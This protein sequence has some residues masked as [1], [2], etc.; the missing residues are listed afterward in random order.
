MET[1]RTAKG[2][3]AAL[4]LGVAAVVIPT[5]AP[6]GAGGGLP[7][8]HA[9]GGGQLA[10]GGLLAMGYGLLTA[11][12]PCVYPL[13]PITVS[14]FG[15]KR[16]ESHGKALLLTSAYVLGMAAVFTLLGVVAA[17]SGQ[18]FGTHLGSAWVAVP[19]ALALT[20]LAAS[21]FGAFE[22]N[23]PPALTQKLS[24]VGGAGLWGA[25]LMGSVSG[26]LAAPCTGPALLGLLTFVAHSQRTGLG[27]GLLFLYAL[28]MG[29][30]FFLIGAFAVR[31]PKGGVWM[32]WVKSILGVVLLAMAVL[33]VE[34]AVP[35]FRELAGRVGHGVG[36]LGGAYLAG[37]GVAA[38]VLAGAVHLSFKS[39]AREAAWKALGVVLVVGALVMRMGA[40]AERGPGTL[41]VKAGF[42]SASAGEVSWALRFGE[43]AK[44][45][46]AFDDAVARARASG[47]PV[48]IDFFAEWC[49]ACKELDR[50]TYVSPAVVRESGRF[51]TIKVDGTNETDVVGALEDKF[52]VKG[53]PTVAFISS[54][55]EVLQAPRVTGFLPAG[56][57]LSELKKVQ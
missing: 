7:L 50:E 39:H 9:L 36:H 51:L 57:F 30:P 16:A 46:A 6:T 4:G 17:K 48:M 21:M 27:A 56:D 31:L 19:V 33:Y 25:V 24:T 42:L 32:E 54:K 47:R 49:A 5:L 43:S 23:L 28:G 53:L 11:L 13:I 52:E 35:A 29:L 41:W 26:F 37:L 14:V 8:E 2:L 34:D 20:L 22:L 18:V 40:L 12:T 15:A 45:A 55:G 1:I 10:L 3:G 44:S 38:G